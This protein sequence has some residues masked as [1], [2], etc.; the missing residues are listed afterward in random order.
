MTEIF[1]FHYF[2][3]SKKCHY[4]VVIYVIHHGGSM[5]VKLEWLV[6][7]DIARGSVGVSDF[8]HARVSL[9]KRY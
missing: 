6:V 5:E 9:A 7:D 8:G 1:S 3:M 2:E 4:Q